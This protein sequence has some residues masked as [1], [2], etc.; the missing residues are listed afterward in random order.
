MAR[1]LSKPLMA[2]GA[3]A[4]A[5]CEGIAIGAPAEGPPGGSVG[6]LMVGAAEGLG[7]R[8]MRT[9]SFLGWTFE[10]SGGLG[11]TM[12]PGKLGLF[13]AIIDFQVKFVRCQCQTLIGKKTAAESE[14]RRAVF[15]KGGRCERKSGKIAVKG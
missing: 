10:A 7:G 14:L 2:R 6:N 1:P 12:P 4:G 5:A 8:L 15:S 11:G 3:A 13:S 9:V